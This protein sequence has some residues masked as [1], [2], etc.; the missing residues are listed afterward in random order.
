MTRDLL[1]IGATGKTGSLATEL[2]LRRGHRVRALVH[3]ADERSE[4]LA[5][6]G[7]EIVVGDVHDLDAL[8]GAMRGVDGAYFTYPILPGL[9]DAA[10]LEDPVGH[11]DATYPLYGPVEMD[12]HEIAAVMSRVLGR[13]VT[14][15][16]VGVDE[17]SAALAA[18]G[19]SPHLIQHLNHVSIDYRNGV[20]SGTDDVVKTITGS[21][22]T[23]VESFVA[24]HRS[25][26]GSHAGAGAG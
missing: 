10:V 5:A 6:L 22:P 11:E 19:R 17:F 15:I 24:A 7:A 26:F 9:L 4:G 21:D 18:Q 3:R 20:F 12:H 23:D 13:E 16:P 8:T 25:S 1:I 2:L 14:Y